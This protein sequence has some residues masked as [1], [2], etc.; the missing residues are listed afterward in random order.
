[1]SRPSPWLRIAPEVRETLAAGGAVVALESTLVT[2][3]LPYPEN[4]AAGRTAEA[5]VRAAGALPATVA[6][7]EGR[8]RVGLENDELEDLARARDVPKVSRADLGWALGRDGWAGTTVS[9]TM[10]AA[11][12][13]G[14]RVFATGGIGGVHRGGEASLDIS[15]DLDELARTPVVVVCAGP[16]AILDVGRTLEVL[17]TRG[18]PVIGWGTSELAG[19]WSRDSG[20]RTP[21][22]VRDAQE[23]AELVARHLGVGL[24]SGLLFAVPVPEEAALPREEVE[25]A[26]ERATREARDAGIVGPRSTPWVLARVAELTDGR[27]VRANVALLE[28]DARVAGEIAVALARLLPGGASLR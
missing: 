3:G 19:F 27:S 5:A 11:D 12:L 22:S 18:V 2:H 9:A 21:H 6:L 15:A 1:V 24:R 28:R 17:E 16:K 14:V 7:R 23:A 26:V 4:L 8:I 13:A 10:I 25:A 20:H